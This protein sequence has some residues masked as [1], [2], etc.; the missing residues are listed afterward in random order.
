MNAPSP[1]RRV[2]S[3]FM[4]FSLWTSALAFLVIEGDALLDQLE[5]GHASTMFMLGTAC[6]IAGACIG[7]FAIIAG[8]GLAISAAFSDEPPH[9]QPQ[10]PSGST[11]PIN[12]RSNARAYTGVKPNATRRPA[13]LPK[14][15]GHF[16]RLRS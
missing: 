7:L 13:L 9:Q 14:S 16:R 10:G 12:D 6:L 15:K 11:G 4:S 5:I 2:R 8:I 1:E 3:R